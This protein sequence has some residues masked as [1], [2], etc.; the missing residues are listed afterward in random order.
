MSVD[1]MKTSSFAFCLAA[2]A[3]L[4]GCATSPDYDVKYL[5]AMSWMQVAPEYKALCTQTYNSALEHVKAASKR[6]SKKTKVVVLDL[7]ETVF[8]N[9]RAQTAIYREIVEHGGDFNAIWLNWEA[10]GMPDAVPGSVE[11]LQALK[12]LGVKPFFVTSRTYPTYEHTVKILESFGVTDWEGI[13]CK[14]GSSDKTER[15]KAI[16]RDYEVLAYIGDNLNDLPVGSMTKEDR[17]AFVLANAGKFGVKFFTLP[18]P[19]YGN[20]ISDVDPKFY[21]LDQNGQIRSF[22]ASLP[23]ADKSDI[24]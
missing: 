21:A 16:E 18:N 2:T 23:A 14:T 4:A 19:F 13:H 11:F 8:L 15:F 20:W 10:K 3:L 17:E 5:S 7:D 22:R 1:N 12:P 24:Q 6:P 9:L